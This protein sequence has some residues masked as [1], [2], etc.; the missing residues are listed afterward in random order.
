MKK[1]WTRVAAGLYHDD[2]TNC[3]VVNESGE[4][5]VI[6][7]HLFKLLPGFSTLEES[8]GYVEKTG[9]DGLFSRLPTLRGVM[10]RDERDGG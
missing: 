6:T 10:L 2:V 3:Y 4:W 9:F 5:Y 8:K 7:P 1:R